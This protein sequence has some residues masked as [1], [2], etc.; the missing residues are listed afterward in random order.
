MYR[1]RVLK[2]TLGVALIISVSACSATSSPD[3]YPNEHYMKV[4]AGQAEMD[5]RQCMAQADAAIKDPNKYA[6]YAKKAGVGAVVGAGA[7]ALGGVITKGSVG[8]TTAAG[9]A[10]G[11]L[12]G[13]YEQARQEGERSPAYQRFVEFCLHDKGY[14]VV[15]WSD[16]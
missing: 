1:S 4:G 11:A 5:K 15:G 7:G 8:R 12:V 14:A 2:L 9:A 3:F 6:E 16:N 10:I 13:T